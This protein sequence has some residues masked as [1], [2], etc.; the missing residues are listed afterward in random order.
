VESGGIGGWENNS[1]CAK[2]KAAANDHQAQ[3]DNPRV[4]QM[5]AFTAMNAVKEL[6]VETVSAGLVGQNLERPKVDILIRFSMVSQ[7]V[8]IFS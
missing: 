4:P 5:K 3:K 7:E 6:G 2:N 1:L 8:L